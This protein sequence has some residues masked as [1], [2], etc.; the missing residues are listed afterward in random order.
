MHVQDNAFFELDQG[1][2]HTKNVAQFPLHHVIYAPAKFAVATS[3]GLGD[4]YTRNVITIRTNAR[5]HGQ[6]DD[7]PTLVRN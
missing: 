2:G 3:K 1:Q 5:R 4:G 6:T 7:G